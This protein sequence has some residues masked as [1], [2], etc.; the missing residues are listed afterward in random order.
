MIGDTL[1]SLDEGSEFIRVGA[2]LRSR[3][4]KV[5]GDFVADVGAMLG[6]ALS[7]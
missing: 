7:S 5:F 6:T 4:G 1:G 2:L 3:L